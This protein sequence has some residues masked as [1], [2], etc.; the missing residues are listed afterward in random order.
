MCSS[1]L[2]PRRRPPLARHRD[3]DA[4]DP[5]A[6]LYLGSLVREQAALALR[7]LATVA[8][9]LGVVPL[10]FW[11]WPSLADRSLLG[12][13]VAWWLLGVAA[14]PFLLLVGWRHL[15]RTERAEEVFTELIT[16]P[17]QTTREGAP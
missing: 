2:P 13:P 4:G 10:V 3:L 12:V 5:L 7:T 14:Y 1:D 6:E 15:R 16:A 17:E 8:L 11:R 9:V